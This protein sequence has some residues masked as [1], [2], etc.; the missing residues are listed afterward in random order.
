MVI[1]S[2]GALNTAKMEL[3]M[4]W[5]SRRLD[6]S[7]Y[8]LAINAVSGYEEELALAKKAEYFVKY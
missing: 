4:R 3:S 2:E 6:Q 5:R 7:N 8:E 1:E